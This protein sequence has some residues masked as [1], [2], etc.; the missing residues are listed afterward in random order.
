MTILQKRLRRE[1]VDFLNVDKFSRGR[2]IIIELEPGVD[3]LPAQIAFRWK[4]SRRR[5]RAPVA[6]LMQ[7]TIQENVAALRREKKL[8]RK[9][10]R[11][12][13]S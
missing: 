2:P 13:L 4:G 6:R 7:W 5:Y 3:T 10:R 8:Q 9:Q 11:I 1:T 12:G